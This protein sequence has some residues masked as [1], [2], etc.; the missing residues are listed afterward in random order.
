L[1]KD[2]SWQEEYGK[3]KQSKP[4]VARDNCTD[5]DPPGSTGRVGNGRIGTADR[6]MRQQKGFTL[7][8]A[9]V[10]SLI[11]AVAA[12]VVCGLSHRCMVNNKRGM[13]YEQ[14]Y[15]LVDECLDRVTATGLEEL[16]QKRNMSG[17]FGERYP[18]YRYLL[19]IEQTEAR[20]LWQVTA[21]VI[22]KVS[23]DEYKVEA[24]TLLYD[25]GLR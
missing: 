2:D 4:T 23:D 10:G 21:T 24:T 13:E 17:N 22:W 14:A 11:L 20:D 6:V 12:V 3:H 9:L 25:L 16:I 5:G 8:E 19:E 7:V 15:R 18:N 1:P